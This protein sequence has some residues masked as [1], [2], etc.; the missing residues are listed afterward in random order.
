M[1]Y[2]KKKFSDIHLFVKHWSL[3]SIIYMFG[4]SILVSPV[5][6]HSKTDWNVYLPK[7]AGWFDF[8]TGKYFAGGQTV[9]TDAP[10][11]KIP[12]FVKAGSIIPL[13]KIIQSST[14]KS[15]TLEIRVNKGANGEFTLYEDEGENYNYEKGKYSTISFR[16]NEKTQSLTIAKKQGDFP[17]RLKK[18]IL[19]IVFVTES[20]GVGTA[21]STI[22]TK[23]IYKG[24]KVNVK[25]TQGNNDA[26]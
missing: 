17:D 2:E 9:K 19:N 18:R 11:D 26:N 6:E 14:E 22:K 8:W 12:L 7:S 25:A 4:K 10:L 5:T 24:K 20:E 3:C 23:V 21:M 13:G 15:E 1:I 16:W